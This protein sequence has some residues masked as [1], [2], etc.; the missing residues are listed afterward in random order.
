MENIIK[1]EKVIVEMPDGSQ[2]VYNFANATTATSSSV[3]TPQAEVLGIVAVS[4]LLVIA[5][6]YWYFRIY[7]NLKKEKRKL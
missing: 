3:T 1:I 7:R 2:K 5:L 4:V 6:C